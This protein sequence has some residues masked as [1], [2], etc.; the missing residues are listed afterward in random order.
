MDPLDLL[1]D[2]NQ[3]LAISSLSL[4]ESSSFTSERSVTVMVPEMLLAND[5]VTFTHV[6][7]RHRENACFREQLE[8]VLFSIQGWYI[9]D[10]GAHGNLDEAKP[11]WR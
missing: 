1:P 10:A 4:L 9:N 6:S 11:R 2:I 8:K 7:P 3:E 5:H